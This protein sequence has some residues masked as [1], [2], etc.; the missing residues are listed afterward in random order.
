MQDMRV[1]QELD[2]ADIQDHVQRKSVAGIL[3]DLDSVELGIAQ[4]G[5]DARVG[6]TGQRAD[7]VRV[8][9][10]RTMSVY[11][12]CEIGLWLLL[13]VYTAVL[14]ALEVH[15]ASP[16]ELFLAFACLALSVEIPDWLGESL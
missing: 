12:L 13:G 11:V 7:V 8:P 1:R 4:W 3:E 16:D 14:A 15:D 5:D 9:S 6:E 2:I 10:G